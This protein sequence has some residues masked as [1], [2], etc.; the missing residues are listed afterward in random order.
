MEIPTNLSYTENHEWV[1]K[2]KDGTIVVGITEYAQ[3]ALGDIV[4]V[5]FEPLDTL[6]RGEVFCTLESV[7]AVESTYMPISG[8]I[9][10]ENSSLA[11]DYGIINESPYDKGWLI[12]VAPSKLEE[13]SD[14]LNPEEYQKIVNNLENEEE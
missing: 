12:K 5:E 1:K 2:N 13:L 11:D 3:H 14:L 8:E 7:K 9:I 10:E 6:N 4:F